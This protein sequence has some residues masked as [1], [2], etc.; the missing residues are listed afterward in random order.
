MRA[1]AQIDQTRPCRRTPLCANLFRPVRGVF[2]RP[3]RP[4]HAWWVPSR[5]SEGPPAAPSVAK[6]QCAAV[7]TAAAAAAPGWAGQTAGAAGSEPAAWL[8]APLPADS[9]APGAGDQGAA[10]GC[11]ACGGG[12]NEGWA[13]GAGGGAERGLDGRRRRRS[14]FGLSV[15][16]LSV[17]ARQWR[18]S[19]RRGRRAVEPTRGANSSGAGGGICGDCGAPGSGSRTSD[20]D[21]SSVAFLGGCG[22]LAVPGV[23][24]RQ[25]ARHEVG[26]VSH[27]FP[28]WLALLRP[29]L[30]AE[31]SLY[32][33][34]PV[35]IENTLLGLAAQ[36]LF[37][38][39]VRDLPRLAPRHCRRPS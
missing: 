14:R 11:P 33:A 29:I 9:S 19:R 23:F 38:P 6:G 37:R 26:I 16:P 24:R 12:P 7:T 17:A 35:F 22:M 28:I 13:A 32:H 27:Y 21:T 25:I 1:S 15:S 30:G 39:F 2:S 3:L 34:R 4:G 18:R 36:V 20:N 5:Q 8:A 10:F 31:F